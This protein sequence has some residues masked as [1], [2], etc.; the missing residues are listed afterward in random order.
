MKALVLFSGGLDSTTCLFE[1]IK[2][3][4]EE[5]VIALSAY[6]GQKHQ[7]E[8]DCSRYITEKYH[9]KHQIIDL[10]AIFKDSNCS[11]LSHSNEEIPHQAYSEQLINQQ[12]G[13]VTTY[14]PFRNGLFLSA[15]A[16][17]A[18]ANNCEVIYYGAHLDDFIHSAYPDTSQE[19]NDAIKKAIY[20]G[21][22]KQVKVIA[23]YIDKD[24]A[25]IVKI[26]T[27]LKVPYELTWS[28]YEGKN[29][30]C[31]RCGTCLDRKAAFL[32]NGLIDP[33]EYEE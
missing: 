29:K 21:S 2:K 7:K 26:G 8:L 13:I 25:E 24:K 27:K 11:L 32:K 1:A 30:A 6:Y 28:C 3:Y 33:I 17:V 10:A 9:I 18:I 20:L 16:S 4:G 19:F 12:D 22:G 5:E 31:G 15:A 23:P 14:V